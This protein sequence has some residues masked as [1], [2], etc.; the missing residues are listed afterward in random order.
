M[1][2]IVGLVAP[3]GAV[4]TA[5]PVR[6]MM[7]AV[8]HRG[9]DGEG[10]RLDGPCG[11][12]HLRLSIIDQSPAAAQ[13]MSNED[14][15]LWLVFNGEIYN[16]LELTDEL[17]AKGH[18]FRSR[19]DSEVI[20]HGFEEWGERCLDRFLGMWA[21]ALWDRKAR[22]LFCARD[23]AGMKP[24]Y[25]TIAGGAFHFASEIK[26]LLA[27]PEVPRRIDSATVGLFLK[28]HVKDFD[29]RTSFEGISQL[30]PA[31]S[32]TLRGGK[33]RVARYWSMPNIADADP[34]REFII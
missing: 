34:P 1:C 29:E 7:D 3:E 24:F 32:L 8:L 17:R 19:A 30:P 15:S 9:P 2:G 23:R 10:C 14:G 18:V 21:F 25:Y 31:H 20:L 22:T 28:Y 13:P 27:L 6:A 11:L 4:A 16:Y 5:P 26:A 12:G 33:L